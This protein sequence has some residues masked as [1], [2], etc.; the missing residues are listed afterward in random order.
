MAIRILAERKNI[1][2]KQLAVIWPKN[3]PTAVV[4]HHVRIGTL[5]IANH[6]HSLNMYSGNTSRN[7]ETPIMLKMYSPRTKASRVLMNSMQ[8][9]V[10]Y[11][12]LMF[13]DFKQRLTQIATEE[14]ITPNN[15]FRYDARGN[16]FIRIILFI[17]FYHKFHH[18]PDRKQHRVVLF[19]RLVPCL[20]EE[21]LFRFS[22]GE[23]FPD[24]EDEGNEEKYT[25]N[26]QCECRLIRD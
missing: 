19:L 20:F 6:L 2:E 9:T 10:P 25:C 3:S 4:I 11:E 7:R 26:N 15:H 14:I 16:M 5:M 12:Q 13:C 18:L 1:P 22:K 17:L 23:P 24:N 21:I 8:E